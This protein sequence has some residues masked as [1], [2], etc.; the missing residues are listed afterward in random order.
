[1]EPEISFYKTDGTLA[2]SLT[3]AFPSTEEI[4]KWIWEEYSKIKTEKERIKKV[5]N[6]HPILPW[7]NHRNKKS[8]IIPKILLDYDRVRPWFQP[9]PP[10]GHKLAAG[11]VTRR[12]GYI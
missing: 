2:C 8:N 5:E 1:M 3:R 11:R 6:W 12:P 10:P 4:K 9:V 7:I